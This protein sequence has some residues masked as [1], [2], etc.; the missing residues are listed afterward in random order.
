MG[1]VDQRVGV[2]EDADSLIEQGTRALEVEGDLTAGRRLFDAAYHE[3]ER[4][5]DVEAMAK[6]ALG[7]AGVWVHEHRTA[8]AAGLLHARLEHV[9]SRLDPGSPLA[10]R[11]RIRLA[12]E[13]DYRLSRSEAVLAI[14]DEARA[15]PDPAV[16]AQALSLAHHC[17]LGPEHPSLRRELADELV[18]EA[19]RSGRRADLLMGLLWQTTDM[20][21]SGDPHAE[22]RLTELRGLLADENHLAIGFVVSAIEVMLAIR[23]GRLDEAEHLAKEC[24]ERGA[25]AGD[26]D[27]TAWYGA[28]LVAIRWYQGRL[29]ELLPMLTELVHSPTLSPVD[30]SFFAGL[31]LA[32]AMAGD[33]RTADGALATLR[34]RSLSEMPRSSSWLVTMYGLIE[35][36]HLL[37]NR[38]AAARAYDLLRPYSH[39]PMTASLAVACFGSVHHALGV[40]SLTVGDPA[41]AVG[42]LREAVHRNLALGHWPAVVNSRLRLAEALAQRGHQDDA[43]G[44]EQQRA[45]AEDLASLLGVA[46]PLSAATD[47]TLPGTPVTVGRQGRRWRVELGTRSVLVEHSVGMMH[48]AVLTANPGVEIAAVELAAGVDGLTHAVRGNGMSSQPVLD[49]SAVQR[50][51]ARLTELGEEIDAAEA[52]GDDDDAERARGER[53]W[54]IAEL[55]AGT[56]LGGRARA[57]SD[58]GERA[59]LAVGKAIRRALANIEA[60]EPV[61]GAQL[62]GGVHTGVRCWYRPV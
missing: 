14:L 58:D 29:P 44:A 24:A 53:E 19:A 12:G 22:R 56:G 9:L 10:L 21:L 36:A 13:S 50:Y 20:F 40:A 55:A 38:A 16:R 46:M 6:A 54:V 3:A 57:F 39:L 2:L 25:E 33:K 15:C 32:S 23:A 47:D 48:L 45:K 61:I 59:R 34:G 5:G 26:A 7:Q 4:V 43:A 52:R 60:A 42:H 62:R 28:Q 37:D 35:A 17:L 49:R 51:R 11:T 1:E 8:A 31:A 18:G 41:R 27:A 30:N